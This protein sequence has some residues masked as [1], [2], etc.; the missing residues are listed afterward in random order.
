MN[1]QTSNTFTA[2]FSKCL[3]VFQELESQNVDCFFC[4]NNIRSSLTQDFRHFKNGSEEDLTSEKYKYVTYFSKNLHVQWNQPG[5]WC[6][7][8]HFDREN[9]NEEDHLL[10]AWVVFLTVENKLTMCMT[11]STNQGNIGTVYFQDF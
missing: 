10:H 3:H 4:M 8:L 9:I 5:L 6:F 11:H 1:H 7:V 2:D